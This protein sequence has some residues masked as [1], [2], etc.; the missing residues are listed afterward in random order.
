[1]LLR[2]VTEHV[3]NQNWFAVAIDFVI[4]VVGVFI[5]IQVAN[6]DSTRRA[7]QMEFGYLIR[8]HEDI[9]VSVSGLQED[10]ESLRAQAVAQGI[11]I[12][13]LRE[14]VLDNSQVEQFEKGIYALGFI[15][16]PQLYRRTID[17]LTSSGR[18]DLIQ[19][20]EIKSTL[21]SVVAAVEYRDK[22]TQSVLRRVE[23]YRY[24][25]DA[26]ILYENQAPAMQYDLQEMCSAPLVARSVS[27]IRA[28]T[29]ER[30]A[31]YEELLQRYR[32]LLP[33][34]E[35]ELLARWSYTITSKAQTS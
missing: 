1:M 25:V 6:W 12:K 23:H 15:N 11:I 2:R 18:L 5:G 16:P 13:S 33:L 10:I 17:E 7:K 4:V 3:R 14:C 9:R 27:A 24:A 8:L 21:A 34:I 19:R 22:V 31:A 32:S 28:A 35:K 30:A 26:R 29:Q 20:D